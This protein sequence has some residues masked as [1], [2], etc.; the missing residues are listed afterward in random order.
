MVRLRTALFVALASNLSAG[1]SLALQVALERSL[2]AQQEIMDT[3]PGFDVPGPTLLLVLLWGLSGYVGALVLARLVALSAPHGVAVLWASGLLAAS[4]EWL[5]RSIIVG[6][7]PSPVVPQTLFYVPAYLC[8]SAYA[9]I[10]T[11]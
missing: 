5:A 1:L 2:D 10:H 6:A 3:V 9:T 8:A 4:L 7:P 11:R